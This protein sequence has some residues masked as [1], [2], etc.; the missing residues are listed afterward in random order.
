MGEWAISCIQ[1]GC[2]QCFDPAR[3]KQSDRQGLRV[4]ARLWVRGEYG[5]GT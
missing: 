5:R 1:G 3:E 2:E 4:L